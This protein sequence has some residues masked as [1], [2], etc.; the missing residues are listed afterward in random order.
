[1][2]KAAFFVTR[3]ADEEF[4]DECL[5]PTFKQSP[6]RVMVW[7]CIMEGKKGP[8]VVL[9]CPGG[10]GGGMNDGQVTVNKFLRALS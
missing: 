7:A 6:V 9:D 1:M 4:I 2:I 8:L 3:H 5:I 10:K